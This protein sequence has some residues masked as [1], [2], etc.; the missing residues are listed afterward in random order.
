MTGDLAHPDEYFDRL[1]LVAQVMRIAALILVLW[2]DTIF[3][4]RLRQG[5][6]E[7]ARWR[8]EIAA[9]NRVLEESFFKCTVELEATNRQGLPLA[10]GHWPYPC[11]T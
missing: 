5:V 8:E 6:A 2:V 7:H 10:I 3:S 1:R 4:R 9:S 11:L